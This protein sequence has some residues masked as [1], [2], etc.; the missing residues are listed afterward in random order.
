MTTQLT[1]L[2]IQTIHKFILNLIK[3]TAPA[4]ALFFLQL[5]NGVKLEVASGVALLALWGLLADLFKKL[6]DIK[7]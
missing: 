7:G 6:P 2:Q 1:E 5:A 4:V 3:F